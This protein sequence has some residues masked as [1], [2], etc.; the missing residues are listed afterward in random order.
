MSLRERI[1]EDTKTAMRGGEKS[2]LK[3]LRT[4]SAAIKQRE[5]DER[6]SLDDTGITAVIEKMI[7]QRRESELQFR[8]AGREDLAEVEAAEIEGLQTYLPEPL[9]AAELESLVDE[10]VRAAG[11][12]SM[13]DMGK[14]MGELKPKVQGRADM[15]EVSRLVKARLG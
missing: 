7:K 15:S 14:V 10:A 11:A 3:L 6:I 4:L 5:V 8:D 12:S 13:Q 1:L 9:S 2:R